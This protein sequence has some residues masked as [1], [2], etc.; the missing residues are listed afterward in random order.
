MDQ[1]QVRELGRRIVE[2]ARPDEVEN[3]DTVA[4]AWFEDPERSLTGDAVRND[5]TGS[6]VAQQVVFLAPIA[7]YIAEHV[8]GTVTDAVITSVG[9]RLWGKLR[10][11]RRTAVESA[12]PSAT[13][14]LEPEVIRERA[15][16]AAIRR[17]VTGA[18]AERLADV[19]VE[20]FGD[21]AGPSGP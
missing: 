11:R 5:P 2:A 14:G 19:V 7:L 13:P 12:L 8:L 16:R 3:F 4:D 18:E 17:G 10:R 9:G 20:V 21:G 1:E 6:G 15:L